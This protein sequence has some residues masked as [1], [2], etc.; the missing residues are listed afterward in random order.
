MSAQNVGQNYT[1]LKEKWEW[2]D[3]F[4]EDQSNGQW[5]ATSVPQVPLESLIVLSFKK[6]VTLAITD[7]TYETVLRVYAMYSLRFMCL[8]KVNVL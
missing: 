2:V 4:L 3:S 6:C 7:M 5:K 8:W 1:D